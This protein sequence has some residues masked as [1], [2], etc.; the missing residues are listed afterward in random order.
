MSLGKTWFTLDEAVGKFGVT[1]EVLLEWVDEG[2]VRCEREEG[3]V[4]RVNADDIL[5]QEGVMEG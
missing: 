5:L 4:V 3:Q 1:R 2:V